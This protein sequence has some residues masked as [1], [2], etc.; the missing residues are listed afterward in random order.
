MHSVIVEYEVLYTVWRQIS[1]VNKFRE[2][3]VRPQDH[4]FFI[5][6]KRAL[7]SSS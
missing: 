6:K 2:F 4:E 3:R 5:H 7:N 1:E